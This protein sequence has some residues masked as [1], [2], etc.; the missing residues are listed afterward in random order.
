MKEEMKE[1]NERKEEKKNSDWLTQTKRGEAAR[2]NIIEPT[3]GNHLAMAKN[4]KTITGAG[5]GS[6]RSSVGSQPQAFGSLR[7]LRK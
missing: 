7:S 6:W 4:R 1:R 2:N 3:T 5:S